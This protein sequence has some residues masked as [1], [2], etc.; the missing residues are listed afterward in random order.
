MHDASQKLTIISIIFNSLYLITI[1]PMERIVTPATPYKHDYEE[2]D[3][4][5]RCV[6]KSLTFQSKSYLNTPSVRSWQRSPI[7]NSKRKSVSPRP[8][9]PLKDGE[10][11]TTNDKGPKKQEAVTNTIFP[12]IVAKGSS[13]RCTMNTRKKTNRKQRKKD[14]LEMKHSLPKMEL[15]QQSNVRW[16]QSELHNMMGKR[17]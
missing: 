1:Q 2:D 14:E 6:G 13:S 16:L 7:L 8:T 15:G 4:G 17:G 11:S 5:F 3:S 10:Q 12:A 9:E